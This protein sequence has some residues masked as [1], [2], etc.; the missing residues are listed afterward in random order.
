MLDF[1]NKIPLIFDYKPSIVTT[2]ATKETIWRPLM[3]VAIGQ[4][5]LSMTA[6]IDLA[7]I[8]QFHI[9]S[10]SVIG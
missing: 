6:L 10:R 3:T 2:G 9:L 8:R 7:Q 1:S 4:N 5:Q